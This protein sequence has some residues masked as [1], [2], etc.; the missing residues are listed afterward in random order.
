MKAL[1]GQGQVWRSVLAAQ[2]PWD[3]QLSPWACPA[4]RGKR[5][6]GR[7]VAARASDPAPPPRASVLTTWWV[8]SRRRERRCEPRPPSQPHTVQPHGPRRRRAALGPAAAESGAPGGGGGPRPDLDRD[9]EGQFPLWRPSDPHLP[10]HR[11]EPYTPEGKG[12]DGG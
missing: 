6:W 9:A 7:G 3:V 8:E 11:P 12:D 1:P 5:A 2:V 4:P 10:D